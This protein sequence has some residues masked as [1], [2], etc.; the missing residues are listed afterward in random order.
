MDM[1]PYNKQIKET[2]LL[3][4]NKYISLWNIA[5]TSS[6]WTTFRQIL[7]CFQIYLWTWKNI[8]KG[9]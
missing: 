1:S 6:I 5:V 7:I 2:H 9:F 3:V 8:N 4:K